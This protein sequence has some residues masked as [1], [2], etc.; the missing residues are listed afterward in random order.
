MY[1][2]HKS[3][4]RRYLTVVRGILQ[5]QTD[6]C[7]DVG[8][9]AVTGTNLQSQPS[10]WRWVFKRAPTGSHRVH[11]TIGPISDCWK[12]E[13]CLF[14]D[15]W[16]AAG[17]IIARRCPRPDRLEGVSY[18]ALGDAQAFPLFFWD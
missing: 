17:Y 5:F 18:L 7:R 10:L 11:G 12:I 15:R 4:Y 2:L 8:V 13:E 3:R 14:C 1:Y 16:T 9:L 6:S